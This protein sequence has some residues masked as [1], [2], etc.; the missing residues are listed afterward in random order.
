MWA[1]VCGSCSPGDG[2]L[3]TRLSEQAFTCWAISLALNYSSVLKPLLY[4]SSVLKP[5]GLFDHQMT[6][7]LLR[8]SRQVWWH[9]VLALFWIHDL[10]LLCS[11]Q[12]W[13]ASGGLSASSGSWKACIQ[14]KWALQ[15]ATHAI[16]PTKKSAQVGTVVQSLKE[17]GRAHSCWWV[18]RFLK[19][20]YI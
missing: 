5:L 6:G 11:L 16:P 1:T 19:W 8:S 17:Q 7:Q 15:E 2:T 14:P 13:A 20:K 10:S 18:T 9:I 4:T 12:E 3:V